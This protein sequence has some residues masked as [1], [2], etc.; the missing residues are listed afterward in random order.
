MIAAS[1]VFRDA[2]EAVTA[3]TGA[4]LTSMIRVNRKHTILFFIAT[5]S[6]SSYVSNGIITDLFTKCNTFFENNYIFVTNFFP[7]L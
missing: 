7:T 5:Y 6:F 3:E 1:L 2:A 4:R